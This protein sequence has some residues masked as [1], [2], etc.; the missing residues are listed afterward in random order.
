MRIHTAGLDGHAMTSS[1]GTPVQGEEQEMEAG[2][3]TD[4]PRWVN[5][6]QRESHRRYV[7]HLREREY[8]DVSS[9]LLVQVS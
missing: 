6:F 2:E 4:K 9:Q 7:E 5:F 8:E 1:E 3:T